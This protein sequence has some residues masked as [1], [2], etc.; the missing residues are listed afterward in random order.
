[1]EAVM[2]ANDRRL[3]EDIARV[4]GD[5]GGLDALEGGDWGAARTQF[6]CFTGTKAQILTL[7]TCCVRQPVGDALAAAEQQ[8]ALL[9]LLVQKYKD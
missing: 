6:T 7:R 1:V 9:A 3:D 2:L 8:Q 5:V 4:R